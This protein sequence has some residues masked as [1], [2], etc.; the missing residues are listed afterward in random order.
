[1]PIVI[2]PIKHQAHTTELMET[3]LTRVM[4]SVPHLPVPIGREQVPVVEE[5]RESPLC[6]GHACQRVG[7]VDQRAL[8]RPQ[9][10]LRAKCRGLGMT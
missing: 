2:N 7:Y 8:Q 9:F 10:D 5:E 3:Q 6:S 4:L 1:M